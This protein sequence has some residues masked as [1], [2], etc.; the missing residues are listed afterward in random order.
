MINPR[1]PYSNELYHYGVK[2]MKWGVRRYQPY[3][4]GY[5]GKG[6]YVGSMKS[7]TKRLTDNEKAYLMRFGTPNDVYKYRDQLSVE[8]MGQVATRIQREQQL[9]NM[10]WNTPGM[11]AYDAF[12][13]RVETTG[14]IAKG[15]YNVA[16][17]ARVTPTLWGGRSVDRYIIDNRTD[18]GVKGSRRKV[19][20]PRQ[21]MKKK[22][23]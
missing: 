12:G 7:S 17:T 21:S 2:G 20:G 10:R 18:A 6:R 11:Q 13:K 19:A 16:N 1:P 22:R 4:K 23:R 8:E 15:L 5:H 14:K 9:A 3:P